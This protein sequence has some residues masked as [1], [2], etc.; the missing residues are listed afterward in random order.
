MPEPYQPVDHLAVFS[1]VPLN[2]SSNLSA[3]SPDTP[4]EMGVTAWGCDVGLGF[5]FRNGSVA[6]VGGATRTG[7]N[8]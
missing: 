7:G 8:A 6:R 4:A 2:S 1:L 3:Q 5:G